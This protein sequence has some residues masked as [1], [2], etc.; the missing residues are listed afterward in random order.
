MKELLPPK[1]IQRISCRL[2]EKGPTVLLHPTMVNV[3][4]PFIKPT[5]TERGRVAIPRPCKSVFTDYLCLPL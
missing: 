5:R 3:G 2:M 4:G 1:Q